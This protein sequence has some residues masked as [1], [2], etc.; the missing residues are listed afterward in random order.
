MRLTASRAVIVAAVFAGVVTAASPTPHPGYRHL[1]QK[2]YVPASWTKSSYENAWKRWPGVKSKPEDYARAF[3]EHYGLPKAPFDNRGLPLGMKETAPFLGRTLTVDCML[4]HG[5]S[6]LGTS[7]IGLGNSTLDMQALFEDLTAGDGLPLRMP[8]TFTQVRGTTEAGAMAVYLLGRRHPDLTMR[9]QP[10]DLGLND[11]LC[12]DPPAWWLLKKKT[13]MYWT[14]GADQRSVRSIMQFMMSPLTSA[15]AFTDAEPEFAEIRDYLLTLEPPKYPLPIDGEKAAAGKALFAAHCARCHGTYGPDGKYPNKVIAIDE[16]GTDRR[17]YDGIEDRFGLY[18]DTT[19]F[20]KE[21]PGWLHDG[22][23][24]RASAGYQAPPLDGIW[25]TA[26]YFHNGSA[27]TV[28][29]VL[30]S[31]GRPKRF[32]R[33]FRTNLA[34]F[35]PVKLGWRVREVEPPDPRQPAI[36][37]RRVYDTSQPGRGNQGHSFGDSLTDSERLAIIEYM[38]TL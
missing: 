16:I 22:Y 38:K 4:C 15:K 32:T 11:D 17:R 5:G 25:A 29:D 35:D 31:T 9:L 7:Y 13:T 3:R 27:P 21:R 1:A 10:I 6:I 33:S 34:D 30:N 19:W 24:A 14:G 23:A 18:Y 37:R 36:D 20:A 12:E 8:F 28:Y 26:P 2:A